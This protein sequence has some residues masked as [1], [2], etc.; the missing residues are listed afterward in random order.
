[1]LQWSKDTKYWLEHSMPIYY[2]NQSTVWYLGGDNITFEGFGTGT[3]DGN[4]QT[5]YDLVKGVS[6]YPSMIHYICRNAVQF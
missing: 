2:Q 4:G 3:L 5:W 1:M 6:N